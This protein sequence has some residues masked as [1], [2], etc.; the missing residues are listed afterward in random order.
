MSRSI[1]ITGATGKQGGALIRAL[2]QA[3]AKFEIL[4]VTRDTQ[5]ASAQKLQQK[6]SQ[7]KLV[8]GN[9]DNPQEI[10]QKA[11]EVSNSPVWGVFSVQVSQNLT[12]ESQ[13]SC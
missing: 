5:S 3:N 9:M 10:F 6:S 7:I 12:M 13:M 8:S 11:K 4:A 1:L 2:L